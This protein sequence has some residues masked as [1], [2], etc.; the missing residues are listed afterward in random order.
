MRNKHSQLK[1][2]LYQINTEYRYAKSYNSPSLNAN[3]Q[4][5][6]DDEYE[7]VNYEWFAYILWFTLNMK[8]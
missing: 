4:K 7:R 6:D 3:N 2:E 8:N 1:Y 5:N